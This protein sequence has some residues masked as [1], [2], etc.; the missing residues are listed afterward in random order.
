MIGS[1]S[2]TTRVAL[3]MAAGLLTS[4]CGTRVAEEK[5]RPAAATARPGHAGSQPSTDPR[6]R[7]EGQ[8]PTGDV[9]TAPT[10]GS[11]AVPVTG[12]RSSSAQVG[13]A[14]RRQSQA[15]ERPEVGAPQGPSPAG[16]PSLPTRPSAGPD[17]QQRSPVL[18]A[19]VGTYAGLVGTIFK[20]ILEGAQLWV[21]AANAKGGVNGHQIKLIVYDDGG[22]PARHRA[23]VQ[24]A[25]ERRGVIGFFLNAEAISGA[26][27]VNYLEAKR[28]PVV[29]I[30]LG[31]FYAYDSPMYFP[32]ASAA[33]ELVKALPLSI[34]NQVIPRGKKR[35]GT[36]ICVEAQF[37]DTAERVITDVAQKAGL[38]HVYRGR[39]SLAQPDFTAECL[40]ARRQNVEVLAVGLDQNS[41]NRVT[42]ACARQGYHP[43]YSTN[44]IV[45]QHKVNPELAG[46]VGETIVFSVVP[47]RDASHRRVPGSGAVLRPGSCPRRGNGGRVDGWE[48]AGAGGPQ[49][50]RTAH[51]GATP[52]GAVGHQG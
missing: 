16:Q 9:A 6:S 22:D 3:A 43:T 39:A 42:A 28:I 36:I 20:P 48:T 41:V 35:L 7:A 49:H 32:Q 45:D 30:S 37:C 52:G 5:A 14:D 44:I 26:S 13:P 33:E 17:A 47:V 29:G 38:E 12:S 46:A 23:Q 8:A 4:G 18:M 50:F 11:A 51:H 21:S 24:E 19:S 10:V 34:A 40:S 15:S 25:V 27:T 2:R 31:E 1:R